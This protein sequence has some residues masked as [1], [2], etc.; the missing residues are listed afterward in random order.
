MIPIS[1]QRSD[2]SPPRGPRTGSTLARLALCILAVG[3]P[4]AA[5]ALE[6]LPGTG[7]PRVVADAVLAEQRGGFFGRDGLQIAIG[8]EQITALNGEILHQTTLH[9]LGTLG[10]ATSHPSA[11]RIT[12]LNATAGLPAQ[13]FVSETASGQGW[14]TTIQ[15]QLDG[16]AI[17]HQTILQLE[18]RNLQMPRS[19]LGR[20]LEQQLTD[21]GRGW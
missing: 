13:T 20:A 4:V 14:V 9:P 15:N 6:T 3:L 8:L 11:G 19:D 16:Q 5:Q 1:P 10:A 7:D 17:Q 2:A 18:L 21:G 12:I